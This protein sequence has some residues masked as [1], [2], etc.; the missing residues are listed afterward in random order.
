MQIPALASR[1]SPSSRP[2]SL[3][4]SHAH[5]SSFNC[6]HR[7]GP[8]GERAPR[9]WRTTSA[10]PVSSKRARERGAAEIPSDVGTVPPRVSVC[11][12][13]SGWCFSREVAER[14][15]RAR[16]VWGKGTGGEGREQGVSKEG[17]GKQ[18][19]RGSNR[20]SRRRCG[21]LWSLQVF[22]SLLCS[23]LT[24]RS[25]PLSLSLIPSSKLARLPRPLHLQVRSS[26][27]FRE[28][29]RSPEAERASRRAR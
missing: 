1:W 6:R 22:S 12:S 2:S 17:G 10:P 29:S 23:S 25:P 18:R 3:P 4:F 28:I 24:C 5:L 14:L 27:C 11:R 13:L 8:R 16:S 26:S 7:G 21:R 20:D 19:G 15:R 9:E